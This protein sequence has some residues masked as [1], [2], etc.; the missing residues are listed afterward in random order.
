LDSLPGVVDTYP[1]DKLLSVGDRPD[2]LLGGVDSYPLDT[3]H[4]SRLPSV[5]DSYPLDK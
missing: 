2:K 4:D 5:V 3:L 1:L